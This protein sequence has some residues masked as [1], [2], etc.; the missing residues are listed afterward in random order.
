[1]GGS[2]G[3]HLICSASPLTDW[4]ISSAPNNLLVPNE[5]SC[6]ASPANRTSKRTEKEKRNRYIADTHP[7]LPPPPPPIDPILSYPLP[8]SVYRHHGRLGR[9][10]QL[11]QVPVKLRLD[12]DDSVE[13]LLEDVGL[14]GG[15]GG[16]NLGESFSG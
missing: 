4:R 8:L 7:T 3:Y 11:G 5:F 10:V 14:V 16:V 13:Q 12:E 2:H 6:L 15:E 1:V 9:S